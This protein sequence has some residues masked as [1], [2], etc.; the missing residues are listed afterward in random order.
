M[1]FD[2]GLQKRTA[3][4]ILCRLA[5]IL[6]IVVMSGWILESLAV[7]GSGDPLEHVNRSAHSFNDLLDRHVGKP[8]VDAY[9]TVTSDEVRESVSNF[10][11][12]LTYPNVILNDFL[13]GKFIQGLLD[14]SR[15]V[16]NTSLGVG[17]LFDPAAK[18]GM[19]KHDE[20]FGQT[21]G[22]WGLDHGA[23]LVLPTMG[24]SST[25]DAPGLLVSTLTN[26]L[27]YVTTP[28]TVP[29][30]VLGYID[31]RARADEAIRTRDESAVEPYVFTREAFLQHR[32]FLIHDGDPPLPDL[33]PDD[34]MVDL[35]EDAEKNRLSGDPS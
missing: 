21:L 1:V 9:V 11:D 6:S 29:I 17:G 26:V 2:H 35:E 5:V 19:D 13:Q 20:D 30:A 34:A 8:V 27:F 25:R 7:A 24:P 33:I 32:T 28:V 12:N 16:L 4:G 10:Y 22:V 31:K 15:F 23:Y 3:P 14:T 18:W